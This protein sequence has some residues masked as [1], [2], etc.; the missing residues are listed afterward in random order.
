MRR[1]EEEEESTLLNL[2]GVDPRLYTDR[3]T[4][5]FHR[6]YSSLTFFQRYDRHS[7]VP[8]DWFAHVYR[9]MDLFSRLAAHLLL[10]IHFHS[11]HKPSQN[12]EFTVLME[13][14]NHVYIDL[15]SRF[16]AHPPP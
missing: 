3:F 12:P 6:Y 13:L 11:T 10:L 1:A 8:T 9:Y 14:L 5:F 4:H 16:A 2:K 7:M 15:F